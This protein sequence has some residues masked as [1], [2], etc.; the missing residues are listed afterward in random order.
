MGASATLRTAALSVEPGGT[1]SSELTVRNAGQVVDEFNFEFRGDAAGWMT[2]EPAKLSL[3]P[4]AEGT[5]QVRFQPPRSSSTPAGQIPFAV[6]IH[7]KEDP[8]GSSVEEGSI[9]VGTFF[10]ITAEILPRTSRGRFSAKHQLAVDNRG[11]ARVVAA[12]DAFDPDE[13]LRLN[14]RPPQ[15]AGEPGTATLA[16]VHVRPKDRFLRGEPQ[17]HPFQVVVRPDGAPP[18]TVDANY[19]QEAIVPRALPKLL[20]GLGA[21]A[22]G[23]VAAWFFLLQPVI[24]SEAK[25]SAKVAAAAGLQ[26]HDAR[27]KKLEAP[28]G[29]G[30]G[31][32]GGGASPTPSP[33]TTSTPEVQGTKFTAAGVGIDR[34]LAAD[35]AE[36]GGLTPVAFFQVPAGQELSITDLLLQNPQGDSGRLLILRN[37]AV[38]LDERLENFRD[39]DY[40]FVTP[41]IFKAGQRINLQIQCVAGGQDDRCRPAVYYTGTIKNV[42]P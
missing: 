1:A 14:V 19:L 28:G 21:L 25:E 6:I 29:G 40:H 35:T 9:E 13:L 32:G 18:V 15:I 23:L 33:A 42:A 16:S 36:G 5:A 41:L 2:I 27:L 3:F 11:N 34:R 31:P 30:G 10:D 4:G 24:E 7:S 39:L 17:T 22:L 8:E 38:L 37:D 26:S 12:L 20:M